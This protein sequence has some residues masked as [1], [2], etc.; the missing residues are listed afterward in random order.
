LH[1]STVEGEF[2]RFSPLWQLC[3]WNER[4][5]ALCRPKKRSPETMVSTETEPETEGHQNIEFEMVTGNTCS[6]I[7]LAPDPG[8]VMSPNPTTGL[9]GTGQARNKKEGIAFPG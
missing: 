6:T 2:T 5:K 9:N 4:I 3:G 1:V 8:L 7:W